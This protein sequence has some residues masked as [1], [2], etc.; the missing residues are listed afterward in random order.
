MALANRDEAPIEGRTVVSEWAELL[1]T[2]C[3][4]LS[5]TRPHA[6]SA[7]RTTI[8][9]GGSLAEARML[10]L[11]AQRLAEEYGLVVEVEIEDHLCDAMVRFSP[12][13]H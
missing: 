2:A 9:L 3:I 11:L 12:S 10:E 5:D 7:I 6:I 1:E 13:I 8:A 4:A